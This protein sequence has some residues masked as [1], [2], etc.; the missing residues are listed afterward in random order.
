MRFHHMATYGNKSEKFALFLTQ[1]DD[2]VQDPDWME[3]ME[4]K[5]ATL[6][7]MLKK[8]FGWAVRTTGDGIGMKFKKQGPMLVCVRIC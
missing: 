3:K 4:C 5:V 1:P 8:V 7:E 2:F 6:S